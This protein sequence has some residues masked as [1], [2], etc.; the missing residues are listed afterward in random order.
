LIDPAGN[1][2]TPDQARGEGGFMLDGSL[3]RNFR[4]K[5]G[6]L[7]AGV[8]LA[9]ILNNTNICTGGYEQNRTDRS[10]NETSNTTSDKAYVFSKNPKKYYAWGINGM[11]NLV[12]KF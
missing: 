1:F 11:L 5:K 10:Y 4:L 9:N 3:G 6:S 8:M 12:Y 2:H 7:Y